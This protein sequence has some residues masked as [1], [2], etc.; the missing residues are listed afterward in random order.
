[1]I[2]ENCMN[3]VCVIFKPVVQHIL[4]KFWICFPFYTGQQSSFFLLK[5]LWCG[6]ARQWNKVVSFDA[7]SNILRNTI[8]NLHQKPIPGLHSVKVTQH[9]KCSYKIV[10]NVAMMW[11]CNHICISSYDLIFMEKV[12]LHVKWQVGGVIMCKNLVISMQ[13]LC[14]RGFTLKNSKNV[15]HRELCILACISKWKVLFLCVRNFD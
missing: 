5:L 7:L 8:L 15:K 12:L 6:A 13:K 3:L 4:L 10:Y 11:Y 1:M 14:Q 2:N 9:C